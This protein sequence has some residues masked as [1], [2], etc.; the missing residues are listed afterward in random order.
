MSVTGQVCCGFFVVSLT[1]SLELGW[2]DA[3]HS[4]N[5]SRAEQLGAINLLQDLTHW[6]YLGADIRFE[7]GVPY[8]TQDKPPPVIHMGA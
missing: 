1:P 8:T 5:I 4:Q 7:K 6:L 3:F 2:T